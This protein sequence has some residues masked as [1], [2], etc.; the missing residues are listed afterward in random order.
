[1]FIA[2]FQSQK[3]RLERVVTVPEHRYRREDGRK[4]SSSGLAECRT[5]AS[6]LGRRRDPPSAGWRVLKCWGLQELGRDTKTDVAGALA[7]EA[8]T[9]PSH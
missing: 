7:N 5:S 2:F 4:V 8:L 9:C 6:S 1:M 3:L